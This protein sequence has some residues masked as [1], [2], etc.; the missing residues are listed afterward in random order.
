MQRRCNNFNNGLKM[1]LQV[2]SMPLCSFSKISMHRV[3]FCCQKKY[4]KPETQNSPLFW[5]PVGCWMRPRS[6]CLV[7]EAC[8]R[9]APPSRLPL[10]TRAPCVRSPSAGACPPASLSLQTSACADLPRCPPHQTHRPGEF[11]VLTSSIPKALICLRAFASP[12]SAWIAL[13]RASSISSLKP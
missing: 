4:F 13:H 1:R 9:L 10:L 5:L 11:L 8:P 12:V 6:L 7:C 2:F 3:A